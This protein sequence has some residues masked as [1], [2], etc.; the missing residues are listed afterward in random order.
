MDDAKLKCIDQ[1][2]VLA[3]EGF[4]N[5]VTYQSLYD[6]YISSFSYSGYFFAFYRNGD[7]YANV[8]GEELSWWNF[9]PTEP[10]NKTGELCI[11]ICTSEGKWCDTTCYDAVQGAVCQRTRRGG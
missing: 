7:K 10:T 2:G 9:G 3:Y 6:K 1:G 11:R 5:P 4:N 8:K